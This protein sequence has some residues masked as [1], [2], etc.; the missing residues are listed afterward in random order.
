MLKMADM[1]GGSEN[2]GASLAGQKRDLDASMQDNESADNTSCQERSHKRV[3]ETSQT[4]NATGLGLGLLESYQPAYLPSGME[5]QESISVH[6]EKP[7]TD[8]SKEATEKADIAPVAQQTSLEIAAGQPETSPLSVEAQNSATPTWNAGVQSGLRTSFAGKSKRRSR[9]VHSS[10]LI[11]GDG[12]ASSPVSMNTS[13]LREGSPMLLNQ[14]TPSDIG[15]RNKE[16]GIAGEFA[17]SNG[18][19]PLEL[20]SS[21]NLSTYPES[22]VPLSKLRGHF[23]GGTSPPRNPSR[24]QTDPS[25]TDRSSSEEASTG[26]EEDDNNSIAESNVA[27]RSPPQPK[28]VQILKPIQ[29]QLLTALERDAY[30]AALAAEKAANTAAVQ[31]LKPRQ[32]QLLTAPERDAYDASL[33]AEKAANKIAR[34][35]WKEKAQLTL[36]AE[37]SCDPTKT[38]IANG[39]TWFPNKCRP[40][41]KKSGLKFPLSEVLEQGKPIHIER[42]SFNVFAPAFLAAH[43]Q[44]CDILNQKGLVAAF[45]MYVNNFYKHVLKWHKDIG[46]RLRAT[47]TANDALTLEEAKRLVRASDGY[48][49]RSGDSKRTPSSLL[50]SSAGPSE[51]T[52]QVKLIKANPRSPNRIDT[53]AKA[54]PLERDPTNVRQSM[55]DSGQTSSKDNQSPLADAM[56]VNAIDLA[57]VDAERMD[58]DKEEAELLLQQRY[59]PSVAASTTPRCVSCGRSGHRTSTCPELRC[60]SC[61]TV[62]RHPTISCPMNARCG[63]C[64]ERGHLTKD[65]PEKLARTQ[66]EAVPCDICGSKDHLEIACHYIWRSYQPLPEEIRMVQDI[67]VHCYMCGGS[68]HYGPDCGLHRGRVLSGGD[69]W[70]SKNVLK[71]IDHTSKNRALSAGVDYSITTRPN[72]QFSIKGKANDPIELDDSD[73]DEGFIR[74]KINPPAQNGQIRFGRPQGESLPT[75]SYD[76]AHRSGSMQSIAGNIPYHPAQPQPASN[77]PSGPPQGMNP[78]SMRGRN[79]GGGGKPGPNIKKPNGAAEPGKKRGS[80]IAK[81][82]RERMQNEANA[83]KWG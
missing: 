42:F 24:M 43:R 23:E 75:R 54:I 20:S 6:S 21:Q 33:R 44:K 10:S 70:S 12:S 8:A 73:D 65:C 45:N 15:N 39:L 58:I 59:F 7:P 61:S 50:L 4:A 5:G 41:Y 40:V 63:K 67:P 22:Q 36:L 49:V 29:L 72:K 77:R 48:A 53:T 13:N 28:S 1:Q 17:E 80:R 69:T 30:D 19:A 32:L 57:G 25:D 2:L 38:Q 46:D 47:A 18:T 26:D 52:D 56:P 14:E 62:G 35:A 55:A 68:E 66:G 16:P 71:Y 83:R 82:D 34:R 79:N 60:T 9:Q 74:S 37:N 51:H 27:T 11:V 31:R 78:R 81:K 3:K 76:D 64:R